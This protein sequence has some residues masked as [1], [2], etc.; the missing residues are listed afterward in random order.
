MSKVK[1]F[2]KKKKRSILS[3]LSSL[4]LLAIAGGTGVFLALRD[5][6]SADK[7]MDEFY[8]C[9]LEEGYAA[10]YKSSEI[11]ES[12]FITE[13]SF[14][15]MMVNDLGYVDKEEYSIG[16]VYK[17]GNNARATISFKDE[18]E[19]KEVNWDLNLEKADK[20]H[21]LFFKEWK[22][23]VENLIVKDV[24]ITASKEVEVLVDDIN[25]S[26]EELK[27]GKKTLDEENGMIIYTI[28]RMFMG[29]HSLSFVGTHTN[30]VYDIVSFDNEHLI[31]KLKKASLKEEEQ[32]AMKESATNIVLGMYN[33]AFNSEGIDNV[34]GLFGSVDG[35]SGKIYGTYADLLANV[36]KEDGS[37]LSSIDITEY[38]LVFDDYRFDNQMNVTF[39]YTA[40]FSAKGP[41]SIIDGVR[42]R[43]EGTSSSEAVITYSIVDGSWVATGIDMKCIDYSEPEETE[44]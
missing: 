35:I 38:S 3:M 19:D 14:L 12:S 37:T 33:A 23:N 36:N 2:F 5:T 27:C 18:E 42:K 26:N 21:Y 10:L 6:Y 22:V 40:N 9:F 13:E 29:N 20:R 44:E 31:Y 4:L 17:R 34:L 16:K 41:R 24:K 32:T 39:R 15:R 30:T 28:D 43:Y 11:E 7:Y 8:Q 25:I 1:E